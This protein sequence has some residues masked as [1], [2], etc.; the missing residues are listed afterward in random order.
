M[1]KSMCDFH[2]AKWMREERR[3]AGFMALDL[4]ENIDAL[5]STFLTSPIP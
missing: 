5:D 1:E 2:G 3:R 4:Q